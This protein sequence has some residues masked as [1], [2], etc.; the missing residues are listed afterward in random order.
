MLPQTRLRKN[1]QIYVSLKIKST[2]DALNRHG[3]FLKKAVIDILSKSEAVTR[4]FEEFPS[5]FGVSNPIDVLARVGDL[6]EQSTLVIEC[7]RSKAT[8][9]LFVETSEEYYRTRR[10][11]SAGGWDGKYGKKRV[12]H[13]ASE[14]YVVT[15]QGDNVSNADPSPINSAAQQVSTQYCGQV[16]DSLKNIKTVRGAQFGRIVPTDSIAPCIVTNAPLF[17]TRINADEID[18]ETGHYTGSLKQTKVPWLVLNHPFLPTRGSVGYDFRTMISGGED[19]KNWELQSVES[20]YVIN[21]SHLSEFVNGH[22]WAKGESS[23]LR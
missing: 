18:I 16:E 4:V 21:I 20:I 11:V 23:R 5:E 1:S 6:P 3:V 2:E 10:V 13:V 8:R 17:F 7:K 9:W 12:A 15:A 14:G 19:A 22:A